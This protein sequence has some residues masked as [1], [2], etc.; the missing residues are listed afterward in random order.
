MSFGSGPEEGDSSSCPPPQNRKDYR[1][2]R[3]EA[4]TKGCKPPTTADGGR[5]G[6]RSTEKMRNGELSR[7]R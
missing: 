7:E 4:E 1:E 5:G 3:G 6:R 2:R